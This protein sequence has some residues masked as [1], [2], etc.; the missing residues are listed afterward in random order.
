MHYILVTHSFRHNDTDTNSVRSA[1][2]LR[3][4]ARSLINHASG[5][6]AIAIEPFFPVS[7]AEEE[8]E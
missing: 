5:T 2:A 7:Y 6:L 8:E 1:S 4:H 3:T